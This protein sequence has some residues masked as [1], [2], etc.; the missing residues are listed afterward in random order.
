[1]IL[2]LWALLS[3]CMGEDRFQARYD[4]EVCAWRADC[5]GDSFETCLDAAAED[6]DGS[7]CDFDRQEARQCLKDL[8]R[9]DCPGGSGDAG[10]PP[11]CAQVWTCP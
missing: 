6:W 7:G 8:K 10:L 2:T 4:E 3:G 1:M 5:F 11:A 9:M